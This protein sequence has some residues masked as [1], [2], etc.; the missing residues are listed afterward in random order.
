MP[1]ETMATVMLMHFP[2][3]RFSVRKEISPAATA[4][5]RR[6]FSVAILSGGTRNDAVSESHSIP[7]YR[8][9][10]VGRRLHFFGDK[11]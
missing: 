8:C 1:T 4:V 6:S 2:A 3:M 7:R 5:H 9:T 10:L 11:K